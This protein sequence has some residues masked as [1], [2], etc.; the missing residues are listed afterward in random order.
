MFYMVVFFRFPE[1]RREL[2]SNYHES[3]FAVSSEKV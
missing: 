1:F 2:F 3:I